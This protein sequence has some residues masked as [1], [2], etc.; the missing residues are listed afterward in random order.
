MRAC[1]IGYLAT[2]PVLEQTKNG[3]NVAEFRIAFH[4]RIRGKDAAVN[5]DTHFFDFVVWDKAA[6][7]ICKYFSK[8]DP[9]YVADATPRQDTWT[10]KDTGQKR[11]KVY[12]RM[13]EFQFLPLNAKKTKTEEVV[14][15][16]AN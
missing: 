14:T 8:G 10:D 11:S 12:F 16:A 7:V 13:N 9:I 3:T 4:E 6:E 2:Q 5:E 1:G 15:P